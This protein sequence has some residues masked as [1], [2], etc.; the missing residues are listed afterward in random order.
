MKKFVSTAALLIALSAANSAFAGGADSCHFHGH[1][2]AKESVVVGCASDYKDTL[3]TRGKLDASWKAVKLDKA[4]TVE[5]KKMKEWKLTFRNPD[6][7]D[8][9]K[10]SLFMFYTLTGNLIGVNFAGQ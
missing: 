2:P 9:S 5:G 10:Q 6:E 8:T 4:E 3:I 7:K 1:A